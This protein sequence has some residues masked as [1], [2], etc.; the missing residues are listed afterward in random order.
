MPTSLIL[1]VSG[2]IE[3]NKYKDGGSK[4]LSTTGTEYTKFQNTTGRKHIHQT[5]HR[6][7]SLNTRS[8]GARAAV[9][10]F[11]NLISFTVSATYTYHV[12]Y[13]PKLAYAPVPGHAV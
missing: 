9:L 12:F 11:K 7:S 6:A 5:R 8:T 1:V 10:F 13:L 4:E 2:L 3:I